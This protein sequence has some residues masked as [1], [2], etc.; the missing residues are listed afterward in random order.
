MD[1]VRINVAIIS[2]TGGSVYRVASERS[3]YLRKRVHLVVS[4]RAC[5]AMDAAQVLAHENLMICNASSE[6]FSDRLLQELLERRIDL[7][8]CFFSRMLIGG[9]LEAYK[10]RLLN[11]HPTILPACLGMRGFEASMNSG[12]RI[13]GSTVHFVG[14]GMDTGLPVPQTHFYRDDQLSHAEMRHYLFKQQCQSLVQI[15]RWFEQGRVRA[16]HPRVSVDG[17]GSGACVFSPALDDHGAIALFGTEPS[18]TG[19]C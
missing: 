6:E 3:N 8:I 9:L 18:G 19:S 17:A 15:V 5:G 11:F 7:A 10:G 16:D 14:S 1:C 4:D 2:S 12:T 13:L